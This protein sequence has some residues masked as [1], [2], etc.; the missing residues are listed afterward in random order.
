V[1]SKLANQR[2]KRETA[3]PMDF[4]QYRLSDG[5]KSNV[6]GFCVTRDFEAE[7]KREMIRKCPKSLKLVPSTGPATTH[8][9]E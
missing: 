9:D 1:A 4:Q 8:I 3:G 2:L 7:A 6:K 5:K